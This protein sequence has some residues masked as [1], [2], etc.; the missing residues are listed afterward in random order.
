M[1]YRDL[2]MQMSAW[3]PYMNDV[4]GKCRRE[5]LAVQ[6][7]LR[8]A[9]H[10]YLA[11]SATYDAAQKRRDL[12]KE[13]VRSR[14][15]KG[16]LVYTEDI[17]TRK[18]AHFPVAVDTAAGVVRQLNVEEYGLLVDVADCLHKKTTSGEFVHWDTAK[19]REAQWA[20]PSQQEIES[21]SSAHSS[22]GST[23]GEGRRV[24]QNAFRKA[25]FDL[26]GKKCALCGCSSEEIL[27]A[28][29]ILRWEA[30]T[31]D[32]RNDPHN[33]IP[34]AAHIDAA[35]EHGLISFKDDGSILISPRFPTENMN[36]LGIHSRMRLP[37]IPE[38]TP[39][40]LAWHRKDHGFE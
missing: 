27:R 40:Y 33:G 36:A 5:T 38:R 22:Y 35:F 10:R 14:E 12:R 30:G 24:G 6:T 13:Y 37:I 20:T 19:K 16:Y 34:L 39:N 8:S 23:A 18:K 7:G 4:I 26:W 25:L 28:S 29:H 11:G 1:T 3:G 2:C 32:Q 9:M 17:K 31:T 15:E 21:T